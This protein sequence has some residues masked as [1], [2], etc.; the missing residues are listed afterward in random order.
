MI[1]RFLSLM[2]LPAI[3]LT[4]AGGQ[5]VSGQQPQQQVP[6]QQQQQPKKQQPQSSSVQLLVDSDWLMDNIDKVRLISS[7]QTEKQFKAGHIPTA[8]FV[9]WRTE[10]TDPDNEALFSLPSQS[11]VEALLSRLGVTAQTTIV[12]SDNR[13]NRISTRLYWTLKTYGHRDVRI[14]DGGVLAWHAEGHPL[15][16]TPTKVLPTQYVASK[17][18]EQTAEDFIDTPSLRK[19]IVR[20]DVLIDGRPTPQFTGAQPGIT[21]HTN[22]PH[23]RRGHIESAVSIPWKENFT[24]DGKFKS[25]KALREIYA[26]AGVTAD[27]EIVTYCNEGLHAAPAW[28]VLK[29][30]LGFPKVRLYDDSMGVWAN[31]FDTPMSQTQPADSK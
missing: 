28:F 19:S 14:L 1:F 7:G 20:G 13:S 3:F 10:I 22:V 4:A 26:S 11:S 30:M 25:P 27:Q 17:T 24:A 15:T 31:R 6:Q 12:L 5:T 9:D 2:L 29:E 21:F 8:V 18:R 23:K 16:T